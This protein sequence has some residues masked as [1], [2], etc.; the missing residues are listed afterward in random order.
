MVEGRD[1]RQALW[2]AGQVLREA[3]LFPRNHLKGFYAVAVHHACLTLWAYGVVMG[4]KTRGQHIDSIQSNQDLVCLDGPESL[5]TQ[6]FIAGCKGRAMLTGHRLDGQET[7]S[8]SLLDLEACMEI[9]SGHTAIRL[10]GR[11]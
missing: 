2:H 5:E 11:W 3:R 10:Y 1:A 7:G 9:W 4:A 6:R 8:S